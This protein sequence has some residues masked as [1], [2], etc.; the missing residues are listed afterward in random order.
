MNDK[1]DAENYV[2]EFVDETDYDECVSYKKRIENF[3][4]ELQM[5][6]EKDDMNSSFLSVLFTIRYHFTGKKISLIEVWGIT[7]KWHF[8]WFISKIKQNKREFSPQLDNIQ[9]WKKIFWCERDSYGK[10]TVF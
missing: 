6:D 4:Q 7:R 9:F 8:F 10:E 3:K 1:V 2:S 5:P